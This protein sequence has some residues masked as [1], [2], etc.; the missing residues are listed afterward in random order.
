MNLN[1][2][3]NT[4]RIDDE[5]FDLNGET[6]LLSLR[7]G[8]GK[9]VLVQMVVSLFVHKK[10][11]DF[12]D[13]PFKSY[14]T[15]N[16]PTFIMAEWLLDHGQGYFLT[17]MMVR[18]N[19]NPEEEDDLE[20]INFTAFYKNATK[21][22]MDNL[23]VIE[24]RDN[25]KILRGFGSCKAEFEK[26]KKEKNSE[27][28][29][30]DMGNANHQRMYF[31][32][33]N[34]YQ[35]NYKEWES[36]I[37]K[38]NI[39]ESGLSELFSNAKDEKGLVENWFVGAI[40]D[41]L[42]VENS[43]IKGFQNLAFK[44]IKMYRSNQSKIKQKEIMEKY[45]EDAE[46]MERKLE[47]YKQTEVLLEQ[48]KSLIA[49]FIRKINQMISEQNDKLIQ[50]NQQQEQ[51]QQLLNQIEY[52]RISC[53]LYQLQD[54]KAEKVQDRLLVEDRI[55]RSKHNKEEADK[56]LC[57]M[58]C[59]GLYLEAEDF[60]E[61]ITELQEKINVCM[62]QQKDTKEDRIKLG[63]ILYHYYEKNL[64]ESNAELKQKKEEIENSEQKKQEVKNQYQ[65]ETKYTRELAGE[66]GA[67]GNAIKSYDQEEEKF[68]R[69][70]SAQLC[71]NILGEY[72]EGSLEVW[73]KQFDD[74]IKENKL[75]MER[76]S[77]KAM[78]EEKEKTRLG[79]LQEELGRRNTRLMYHLEAVEKEIVR[80]AEEKNQRIILMQYIEAPKEELDNKV[81]LL[82][83][84]QRKIEELEKVKENY[85]VEEK[86]CTKEY[87]NLKQ[88]KVME[89][90][91][92][93]LGFLEE[94]GIDFI[95]GMDW[96]KKNGRSV[97]D[98]QE[99]VANNPFLPFSIIISKNDM[100]KLKE[101]HRE[102]YTN[103]PI[104]VMVREELEEKLAEE[105]QSL[106]TLGNISFF[107]MFN[108]HLLDQKELELLLKEKKEKI[109]ALQEKIETKRSEITEYRSK[110]NIL[111]NQNFTLAGIEEAEKEKVKIKKEEKELQ[112]QILESKER[113]KEL[114]ESL[115]E[116]KRQIE[117]CKDLQ[118]D[119]QI[120][121]EEYQGLVK[122]YK[123]YE[124][125]RQK[126]L[127][128]EKK[129]KETAEKICRLEDEQR[130][131]ETALDSMKNEKRVLEGTQTQ[132]KENVSEFIMYQNAE[133]EKVAADYDYVAAKIRYQAITQGLSAN[134]KE[135]QDTLKKEQSRYSKKQK[136]LNHKN[137][138]QFPEVEYS[139]LIYSEEE[140]DR[141]ESEKEKLEKEVNNAIEANNILDAKISGLNEKI[142]Q[143]QS[144]L[145]EKANTEEPADRKTILDTNFSKR[146][147][148][149]V[150][151]LE[152]KK[153]EMKET[154]ERLNTLENTQ[155]AMAEYTE[156]EVTYEVPTYAL[157]TLTKEELF[158]YQGDLRR[159]L[160]NQKE[161]K[162]KQQRTTENLVK[163]IAGKAE[164]QE[165]FFQ[166]GFQNLLSLIEQVTDMKK[167]L[168]TT[169]ASYI[170]IMEK[171]QVD[172]ENV[173]K[174]RKSLEEAFL[175]YVKDVNDNMGRIDKNSTVTIRGKSLKMLKITVP[176]WEDN[177]ELYQVRVRDF[178]N[179]FIQ[180]GM[181]TIENNQNIEEFLGK[182]ITTKKLYDEVVGMG[183]IGVR[184]YKI[185][186]EREVPISWA[187][188]SA[189]SGGEGF[190]SAFVI[191]SSL[192]SYMRRDET[193]I[194][195]M[196][197]EGKVLIM[198]NPFAQT[199]AEHLLKPLTDMAKK[200]NTQLI[201][202]SG[203]GGD[204]VYNRFDNIYVLKLVSST[205]KKGMQ[206]LKGNH[207]K[208]NDIQK[209][210]LSKFYVEQSS[211][212]EFMEET[213]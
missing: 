2:N 148:L 115:S 38:V 79:N 100:K 211:L 159:S 187:E 24:Q 98:N 16:Q 70:F 157:E 82:E 40:E 12:T 80:M 69:R 112:E 203:I 116:M 200:T 54:E 59:A 199:N 65:Q 149:A 56:E 90:P 152:Q 103:F 160:K 39:K 145:K 180:K 208:G 170:T 61:K 106:I 127:S 86:E 128:L 62:E 142:Q 15:G 122:A 4:I 87:E 165:E 94:L 41:K 166:K 110:Y 99:L 14:F 156:F 35:I 117:N 28:S 30:Y 190:L 107:V 68:N 33:L 32:K 78:E 37:K 6:T 139:N 191:L 146:K 55:F 1:Y 161:E 131:L 150:Y 84:F 143:C 173:E 34:E 101:E 137:R 44:F 196:G 102:I 63:G 10:Y 201:C 19:Q 124:E 119:Y 184:L 21:Y 179:S 140:I 47:E 210:E 183:N 88:G 186:A 89:V 168:E 189:N 123:K 126:K 130:K 169:K 31:S 74:Q 151:D 129:Q 95:Y 43:K 158:K 147:K 202:L 153:K 167:Q 195:A 92:N 5:T 197:E 8:G 45:M 25:G 83:R 96:I 175:E 194:F 198:D 3:G 178:V 52:E 141:L 125:S 162:E 174:E 135:L 75:Q 213:P 144:E 109:E 163:D 181:D 154:S 188:V 121:Q 57:K 206:Y 192:L 64:E 136:E 53:Q 177:Q 171:L 49:D 93:V 23:P 133:K 60:R 7:N 212:F 27:F 155:A 50:E 209:M 9:T 67:I 164:Y 113:Q 81:L 97:K 20:M 42:N 132:W 73:Q 48:Q 134:I 111:E 172:L 105:K 104:P 36:I 118:K 85:I 26:L 76:L 66:I 58:Q 108:R 71:R 11:R 205:M 185:E 182:V 176:L 22:D 29:Y 91:E 77:Q 46:I 114:S 193:D 207:K 138:F 204:S 51:L 18:K 120:R 13:R 72:E 17:G